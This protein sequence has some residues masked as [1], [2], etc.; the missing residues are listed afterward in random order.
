MRKILQLLLFA[1]L[2]APAAYACGGMDHAGY[3]LPVE[4]LVVKTAAGDTHKFHVE[5]ALTPDAAMKGLMDRKEMPEDHGMLFV[6][7]DVRPRNFWMKNTLIPLDIIFI[8]TDGTIRHIHENAV[9]HDETAIPSNGPVQY[10]LELNG[11][12][13]AKMGLKPGDMVHQ[14]VMG[15]S[16]AQ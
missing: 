14:L 7:N 3:E 8:N 12:M 5:L 10:V 2:F 15:N 6:F 4:E 13:A 1:L 9:P 11:G 16:L